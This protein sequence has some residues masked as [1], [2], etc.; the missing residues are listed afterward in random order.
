MQALE[1]LPCW[2]QST[3][4]D[5]LASVYALISGRVR[6]LPGLAD[7]QGLRALEPDSLWTQ[8]H[9]GLPVPSSGKEG[10]HHLRVPGGSP[11][12]LTGS[13]KLVSC[14]APAPPKPQ[15]QSA[16]PTRVQHIPRKW[17]RRVPGQRGLRGTRRPDPSSLLA[18][19]PAGIIDVYVS[20]PGLPSQ[21]TQTGRLRTM[22]VYFLWFWS[23]EV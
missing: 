5:L 4:S 21:I 3:G 20:F 16:C 19:R 2:P 7:G 9:S 15:E 12:P 6:T 11:V 23:L 14:G 18:L 17:L 13:Y 22:G 1:M 10:A 8:P